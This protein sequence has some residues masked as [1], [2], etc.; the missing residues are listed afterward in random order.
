MGVY[1]NELPNPVK[2]PETIIKELGENL[3]LKVLAYLYIL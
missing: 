1:V 2:D 3:T